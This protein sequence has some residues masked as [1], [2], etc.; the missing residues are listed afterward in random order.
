VTV[1]EGYG[2]TE[3]SAGATINRP[4]AQ[5]IGSV[6]KPLAGSSVRIAEDG[7]V[8]IHGPHVF[9]GYYGDDSATREAMTVDGWFRTGDLGHLDSE[10]FLFI[11][12]RKK[13]LIVTAAGKNVAPTVLE[14]PL[15]AHP[16]VSQ[17][18]VVGDARPFIAALITLDPDAT[19]AWLTARGR[20]V[21]DPGDLIDDAELCA[22]IQAAVDAANALVSRA[23]SIRTFRILPSDFVVG[24]ELSQKLSLRRHVI[25]ERHAATIET[26]YAA[27]GNG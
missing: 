24:V 26:I 6:G 25:L 15:R 3:T 23:E 9:A 20:P 16:L 5:R 27:N 19:A 21:T 18:V 1:L 10:G 12:G 2:L 11:T 13:E 22:E 4:D 7:E 17:A 8:E 14:D